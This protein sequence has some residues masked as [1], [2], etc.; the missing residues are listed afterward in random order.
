MPI[1]RSAPSSF[2]A[3]HGELA[4]WTTSPNRHGV[5]RLMLQISAAM[6]PVGKMSERK[7]Y[8]LVGMPSGI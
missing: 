3:H 6:Y 8:L 4:D 2:C 1:T 7:E 5:A